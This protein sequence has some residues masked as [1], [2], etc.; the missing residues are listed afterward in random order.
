M[1]ETDRLERQF[2]VTILWGVEEERAVVKVT[3]SGKPDCPTTKMA[4]SG[5][6]HPSGGKVRGSSGQHRRV[7]PH[8]WPQE[9]G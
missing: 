1:R 5:V 2:D 3:T 7:R 9:D 6:S 8:I 4:H